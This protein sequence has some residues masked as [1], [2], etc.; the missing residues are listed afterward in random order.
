MFDKLREDTEKRILKAETNINELKDNPESK[1][2]I[3]KLLS[4]DSQFLYNIFYPILKPFD[5][6]E[7][8]EHN[9]GV[10]NQHIFDDIS[11]YIDEELSFISKNMTDRANEILK[12]KGLKELPYR[13]E[14]KPNLQEKGVYCDIL[15]YINSCELK[16][17]ESLNSHLKIF[18]LRKLN[19]NFFDNF[20]NLKERLSGFEQ[21]NIDLLE[22]EFKEIL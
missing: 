7:N 22:P 5:S 12:Q 16:E 9:Y 1:N 2:I 14:L 13:Y 18:K 3:E 19:T 17:I 8:I 6:I 11:I 21:K 15:D 10:L 20:S 4:L